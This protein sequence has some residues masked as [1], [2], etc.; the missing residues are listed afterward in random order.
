MSNQKKHDFCFGIGWCIKFYIDKWTRE[1][2]G[3]PLVVGGG[4]AYWFHFSLVPPSPPQG[5]TGTQAKLGKPRKDLSFRLYVQ[6][7]AGIKIDNWVKAGQQCCK[8]GL[9]RDTFAEAVLK[10]GRSWVFIGKSGKDSRAGVH[11]FFYF[12]ALEDKSSILPWWTGTAY[13]YYEKIATGFLFEVLQ[14]AILNLRCN[15]EVLQAS[16]FRR[17]CLKANRTFFEFFIFKLRNLL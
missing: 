10:L 5:H 12:L 11:N 17:K 1:H 8:E 3:P 9:R 13:E 16:Q 4:G 14:L 15:L 6:N 7:T 2:G